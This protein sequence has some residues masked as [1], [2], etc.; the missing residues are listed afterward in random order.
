VELVHDEAEEVGITTGMFQRKLTVKCKFFSLSNPDK[1]FVTGTGLFVN[2]ALP[3]KKSGEI[4]P[5]F[6]SFL[7]PS[8]RL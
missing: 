5:P 7:R 2:A 8:S 1:V 6:L 4:I 3:P